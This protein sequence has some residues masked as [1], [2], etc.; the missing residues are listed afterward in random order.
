M[1]MR[2]EEKYVSISIGGFF[3]KRTPQCQ[4][5]PLGPR[6]LELQNHETGGKPYEVYGESPAYSHFWRAF[7]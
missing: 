1:G 7:G 2:N 5:Y 3:F 4:Q 6:G